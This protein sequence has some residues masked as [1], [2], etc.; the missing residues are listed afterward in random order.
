ME[1]S[2][3]SLSDSEV[4]SE[5]EKVGQQTPDEVGA[6]ATEEEVTIVISSTPNYA[7]EVLDSQEFPEPGETQAAEADDYELIDLIDDYDDGEGE[8]VPAGSAAQD[9]VTTSNT[10]Y[11]EAKLSSIANSVP[12]LYAQVNKEGVI[13][14]DSKYDITDPKLTGELATDGLDPEAEVEQIIAEEVI[15]DTTSG[16]VVEIVRPDEY[17]VLIASDVPEEPKEIAKPEATPTETVEATPTTPSKDLQD[18]S[19]S[20]AILADA[21]VETTA[22][23][24]HTA[25]PIPEALEQVIEE[26]T[27][28]EIT[29]ESIPEEMAAVNAEPATIVVPEE[30]EQVIEEY[31]GKNLPEEL[32][33][34]TDEADVKAGAVKD[35]VAI[36]TRAVPEAGTLTEPLVVSSPEGSAKPMELDANAVETVEESVAEPPEPATQSVPE[37]R[38]TVEDPTENATPEMTI[39]EPVEEA[40]AP[41]I[42]EA[43]IVE[44]TPE[45][46]VQQTIA[47]EETEETVTKEIEEPATPALTAKTIGEPEIPSISEAI[48]VED[49]A[50]V[51]API[52][53]A[54]VEEPVT[55]SEETETAA[56][57]ESIAEVV[58]E[59]EKAVVRAATKETELEPVEVAGEE[60]TCGS[61]V[62]RDC[63]C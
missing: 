58:Q 62:R 28:K 13:I 55:Q 1:Q 12:D 60:S 10:S 48:A 56:P 9:A 27:G 49:T 33:A 39:A 24:E 6:A 57:A 34:A 44:E 25:E 63:A 46:V 35:E 41:V 15:T 61:Q 31:T 20:K 43:E 3:E 54:T 23:K 30:L 14:Q 42:P 32:V 2:L 53:E 26:F 40:T 18:L 50:E 21:P 52:N 38:T 5:F 19:E 8:E 36:V 17:T 59:P 7:V 29:G 16:N 47:I 22:T 45:T 37:E 4:S 51:A 11:F